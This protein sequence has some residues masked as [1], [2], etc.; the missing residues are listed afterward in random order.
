M[1]DL[2]DAIKKLKKAHA[3]GKKLPASLEKCMQRRKLG[4][5]KAYHWLPS[6]TQGDP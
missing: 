3:S 1:N 5:P 4:K 6:A 2:I